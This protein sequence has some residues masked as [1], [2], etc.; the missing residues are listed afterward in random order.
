MMK[1]F[2]TSLSLLI[3]LSCSGQNTV[4]YKPLDT[5]NPIVFR[6]DYIVFKADTIKLG[7]KSFFI[8]GQLTDDEV[9]RYSYVFNSMDK[10]V[11]RLSNGTVDDPMMLY[12]A[13]Y[14]YW[15]DD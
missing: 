3:L 11:Q 2:L 13:P 14:V 7:P 15:I 9:S 10:A 6:G 4:A 8:D 1:G 12:I 5:K